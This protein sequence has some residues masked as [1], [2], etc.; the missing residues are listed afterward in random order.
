MN[1]YLV[2]FTELGSNNPSRGE[3]CISMT[4]AAGRKHNWTTYFCFQRTIL[5]KDIP[6][7]LA[8]FT[9]GATRIESI[10]LVSSDV[11]VVAL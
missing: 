4:S 1:T 3:V 2:K 11:L 8:S 6:A 9:T 10:K 5:A 7:L